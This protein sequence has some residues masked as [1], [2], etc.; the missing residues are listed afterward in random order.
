MAKEASATM[1]LETVRKSLIEQEDTIIYSLIDRATYP[2]NSKTYDD[3]ASLIPGFDGSFAKFLAMET[4]AVHAKVHW[5]FLFICGHSY[6]RRGLNF[7]S[8]NI[9]RWSMKQCGRY[10]NPEEHPFFPD[11]LP[12]SLVPSHE[13]PNVILRETL[14]FSHILSKV[15]LVILLKIFLDLS[16]FADLA[17]RC[18]FH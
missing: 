15:F 6:T 11:A 12:S 16:R 5:L 3:S 4:E 10:E 14:F 1:T 8:N 13:Y 18:L 9:I 2:L 17:F 7:S